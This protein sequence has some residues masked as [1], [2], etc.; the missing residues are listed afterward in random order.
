VMSR[1]FFFDQVDL[2]ITAMLADAEFSPLPDPDLVELLEVA[3][4]LH[5]LPTPDFKTNLKKDLERRTRTMS[6]T[7]A[8]VRTGFRTVTPYILAPNEEL[9]S[10]LKRVFDA[11]ETFRAGKAGA[12]T[13]IELR[14]GD[15]M[16]MVGL[17]SPR[18]LPTALHVHVKD[19]DEVY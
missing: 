10:F 19:A 3:R 11:E 7:A 12:G 2:A 17:G 13:H 14:I 6:S 9:I 1:D 5:D 4:D 16:V 15:S 8:A 18:Q